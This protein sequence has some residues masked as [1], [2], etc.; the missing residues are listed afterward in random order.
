MACNGPEKQPNAHAI[1]FAAQAALRA[2]RSQN[3]TGQ[4]AIQGNHF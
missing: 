3:K 1:F 4:Q 2:L